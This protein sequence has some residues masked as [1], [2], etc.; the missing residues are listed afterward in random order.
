MPIL[1]A[2]LRRCPLWAALAT[3]GVLANPPGASGDPATVDIVAHDGL[4]LGATLWGAAAPGPGI[5]LLHQCNR[6][7]RSWDPLAQ[8]LADAGF[9]VLTL[10]FRGFGDSRNAQ[11]WDFE[12]Q[13]AELLPAFDDDVDR[14]LE[15][16]QS[17][18]DVDGERIGVLGA[19]CGGSMAL[20]LALRHP[21]VRSVGF[22]SSSASWIRPTDLD[23]FANT[24]GVAFLGIAAEGDATAANMARQIFEASDSPR[25]RLILYKGERHGVPLFDQDPNLVDAIVAWFRAGL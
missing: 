21:E 7:R 16:L 6:D 13:S 24:E 20:L 2:L 4:A 3:L 1:A 8:P 5:L 12:T 22:L 19:S 11:A 9:H 25:S 17:L 10:D 23:A 15:F 18:P 14:A